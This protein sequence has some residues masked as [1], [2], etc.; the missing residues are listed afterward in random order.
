[1]VTSDQAKPAPHGVAGPSVIS[2][3]RR[4]NWPAALGA[5]MAL[6]FTVSCTTS[7]DGHAISA[8]SASG[9]QDRTITATTAATAVSTVPHQPPNSKNNGTTFDPC[10]AY[11]D[12]ELRSVGFDPA[13]TV[14]TE[15]SLQRG[16]KY[17]GAGFRV[18]I[19][20][21]NGPIDRFYRQDL[22]AGSKPI[23]IGGRT[24]AIFRDEPANLRNCFLELPSQQAT[25]GA[26]VEVSDAPALDQ[27]PDS[28]TKAI[29]VATLT[30]SK[31][32]N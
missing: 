11:T 5:A 18:Q 17:Y 28:C 7:T 21:L 20:V 30:A 9:R 19:S 23:T 12:D 8:G 31:L 26:I 6:A 13:K 25:V 3:L 14:G 4:V 29:E 1:M 22:F 16:C 32:P 15:S 10:V 24:G 27:I 2:W